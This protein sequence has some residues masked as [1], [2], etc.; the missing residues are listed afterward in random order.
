MLTEL[1]Q[2]NIRRGLELVEDIRDLRRHRLT[3]LNG[4]RESDS[5]QGEEEREERYDARVQHGD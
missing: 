1:R 5:A 2:N 4:V 3:F